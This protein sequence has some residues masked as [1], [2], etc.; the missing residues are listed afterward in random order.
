[1]EYRADPHTGSG[2]ALAGSGLN[3][4]LAQNLGTGRSDAFQAGVYAKTYFGPAYLSG[5]AAF[6]NNWLTTNRIALGD[7]LTASFA[8]QSYALRGE[9]GYRYTVPFSGALIGVTPYGALQTQWFHTPAYSETDL[10]GGGFGLSYNANTANDT[11]SELGARFDDFTTWNNKP[12][13][14]R[15]RLAWAHDWESGTGLN[16]AFEALPGSNFT[17]NGAL[18]AARTR[19]SP[20]ASAQY[21]FTADLS[22]TA[23]FDGEFA[24]SAQTYAGSGTL[25]YTW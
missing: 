10:T 16:A 25:K 4:G 9:A 15:G 23:K 11:R 19:R 17:V 8:G 6:G 22:F 12:L 2:F 3:W 24:P 7:Q 18:A 5:A 14:L 21:F 1:M 13:I 20:G